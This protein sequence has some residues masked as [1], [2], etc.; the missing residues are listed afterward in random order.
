VSRVSLQQAKQLFTDTTPV[1]CDLA[2][3]PFGARWWCQKFS[4]LNCIEPMITA[5]AFTAAM[6]ISCFTAASAHDISSQ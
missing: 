5:W 6:K 3:F 4:H 1:D 2:I